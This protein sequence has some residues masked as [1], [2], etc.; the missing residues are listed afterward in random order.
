[1]RSVHGK[2][3]FAPGARAEYDAR[4]FNL[5]AYAEQGV[6]STL[7][8]DV[9]A[10]FA[11]FSWFN[12]GA[13]LS[14][15]SPKNAAAGIAFTGTRLEGAVQWHD[16][17]ISAGLVTEGAR[18]LYAPIELD[19]ALR[20]VTTAAATGT[21]FSVRGPLLRGWQL[22]MDV[23]NW[24]AAGPYRPQTQARTRIFFESSFLGR[25]PRNNFHLLLS[26]THEYRSTTYVPLGVNPIGQ[27]TPGASV[28][29]TLLEIRIATAV[30]SWQFRNV[31]GTIYETY[32]GYVMPRLV[33]IYGVRWEFWN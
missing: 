6:D 9:S 30:I 19:T 21:I 2:S 15:T 27:Q 12:L 13:A 24:S 8:T 29:S 17:W 10:R 25:F 22:D 7:R 5:S 14:R 4:L 16:R 28:I 11:P 1:L 32:P 20:T 31:V 18:T 3:I 33:N 26:G 23:I